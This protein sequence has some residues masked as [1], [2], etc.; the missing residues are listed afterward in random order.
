MRS[1]IAGITRLN[2]C[3]SDQS[4]TP[5]TSINIDLSSARAG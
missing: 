4:E 1:R 3:A 5:K 2:K